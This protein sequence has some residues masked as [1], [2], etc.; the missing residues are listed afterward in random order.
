MSVYV[1]LSSYALK[2][3]S[4]SGSSDEFL[5]GITDFSFLLVG[6]HLLNIDVDSNEGSNGDGCIHEFLRCR[7]GWLL[8][9]LNSCGE[10]KSWNF[11]FHG[12]VFHEPVMDSEKRSVSLSFESFMDFLE[13]WLSFLAGFFNCFLPCVNFMFEHGS[14]TAELDSLA[15]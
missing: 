6:S 14:K 7:N 8:T 9:A 5:I 3:Q 4:M 13:T 12:S 15:L 2:Y 1:F 11:L 10:R